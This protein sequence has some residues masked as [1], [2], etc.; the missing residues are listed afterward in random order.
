MLLTG[1]ELIGLPSTLMLT[2]LENYSIRLRSQ[3]MAILV[4]M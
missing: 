2:K 4:T 3:Y 1:L